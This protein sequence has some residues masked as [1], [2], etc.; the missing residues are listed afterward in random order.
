[1]KQ[2]LLSLLIFGFGISGSLGQ[3]IKSLGYNSTNG[4]VVANTGTNQLTFTNGFSIRDALSGEN[5]DFVFTDESLG[6]GYGDSDFAIGVGDY[7]FAVK[8]SSSS[9]DW[10]QPIL[11]VE[12]SGVVRFPSSTIDFIQPL[13]WN[14]ASNAATTRTNLGLGLAVLTNTNA[15]NF[16][17]DLGFSTNL[18][19]LWTASNAASGRTAIG[20]SSASKRT[21]TAF[22]A[23]FYDDFSAYADGTLVTNG[24]SPVYGS[25]YS[26]IY[27]AATNA[28]PLAPSVTNGVLRPSGT[29]N[30]PDGNETYY[31]TSVLPSNVRSFGADVRWVTNANIDYSSIV[32]LIRTNNAFLGS[33]LH[34]PVSFTNTSIQWSTN[35]AGNINTITN[36]T[37]TNLTRGQTIRVLGSIR[38]NVLT[39]NIGGNIVKATNSVFESQAGRWFTFEQYGYG[40][41]GIT[42]LAE[43][44]RVWANA[45]WQDAMT[46]NGTWD[47]YNPAGLRTNLGLGGGITTNRTF[48]SYN[49]TNYT[50][51][52][53]TISNGIITGWIQ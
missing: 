50:T 46:P 41:Y 30:P 2:L 40:L 48:V 19:S 52:T 8:Y 53:V 5:L 29:N 34:I 13:A 12:G 25:N 28:S 26:L 42:D 3:T 49:G 17:T 23:E 32:F 21:A 51:N 44:E 16:R 1:M 35:G 11:V 18:S 22:A 45:A 33:F 37:Y 47:I 7:G 36:F 43:V 31:L 15:T 39:M 14:N 38:S 6:S 20:I 9:T 24:F 27:Y 10:G 4:Q